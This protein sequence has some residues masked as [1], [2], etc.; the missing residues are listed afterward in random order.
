MEDSDVP[1]RRL[2]HSWHEILGQDFRRR[3]PAL[4]DLLLRAGGNALEVGE[5]SDAKGL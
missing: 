2:R 3:L 1:D 4:D 5:I